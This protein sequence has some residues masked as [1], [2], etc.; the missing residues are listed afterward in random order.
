MFVFGI[1]HATIDYETVRIPSDTVKPTFINFFH[2][3]YKISE[4][5]KKN[6]QTN[7]VNLNKRQLKIRE[8][9]QNSVSNFQLSKFNRPESTDIKGFSKSGTIEWE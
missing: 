8:K 1:K 7:L 4:N 9:E 2:I 6:P 3:S 5:L